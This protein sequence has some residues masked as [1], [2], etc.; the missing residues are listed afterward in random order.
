[1]VARERTRKRTEHMADVFRHAPLRTAIECMKHTD[2][3]PPVASSPVSESHSSHDAEE[4]TNSRS[5]AS[6]GLLE[7][8]TLSAV[9]MLRELRDQHDPRG[10]ASPMWKTVPENAPCSPALCPRCEKGRA[11]AVF[12]FRCGRIVRLCRP[13]GSL[14]CTLLSEKIFVLSSSFVVNPPAHHASP[15]ET[16]SKPQPLPLATTEDLH[17]ASASPRSGDIF[18]PAFRTPVLPRL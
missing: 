9:A 5:E 12:H 11:T 15:P 16:A 3:C 14:F 17:A 6:R 13:C 18:L 8:E 4:G 10:R 7:Y 1:M 2:E